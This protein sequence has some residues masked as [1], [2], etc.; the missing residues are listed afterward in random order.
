MPKSSPALELV[1]EDLSDYVA[2]DLTHEFIPDFALS[3][4]NPNPYNVRD[5]A[6]ADDELIESIREVGLVEPLVVAPAMLD[7]DGKPAPT[8]GDHDLVAGHR[9]LDGLLRIG[10]TTAPVII[11]HDL[12]TRAKQLEA[13][14][15]ENDRRQGL[16]PIEQAKGYHQ[17]TLFGVKQAEIAKKV[18][19]DRKTVAGRLKL[20][21]LNS[22]TQTKVNDGQITIDDAIAIAALP[23]AEQ[24]KLAKTAGTYSFKYDLERAQMR[25]KKTTEIDKQVADLVA[26]GVPERKYPAGKTAWN[27]TDASDGMTSLRQTFSNEPN[28]HPG[29]L[30]W[31]R[32]NAVLLEYVCTDIA[33]HD[34][35]L[36]EER[37]LAREEDER[38]AAEHAA[39]EEALAIAQR[40]RTDAI[41]ES[42]RPG[43]RLDPAVERV[44][45]LLLRGLLLE[46]GWSTREYF[47]ALDI[48][49][50][51]R[52]GEYS[53]QW[54]DVDIERFNA[55][56]DAAK[57]PADVLKLLAAYAISRA[58][59][60]WFS[61]IEPNKGPRSSHA[62]QYH[63]LARAYLNVATDAGHELTPVEQEL[64]APDA[65]EDGE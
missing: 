35:Q 45:R 38:E 40:L 16:T 15:V 26:A 44:L 17:L 50:E 65:D 24:T 4:I 46:L 39:R 48:P 10:A 55:H 23:A 1:P 19:V 54:K 7:E 63:V 8:G 12:D 27:V 58:E 56:I 30:A 29:C 31:V 62:E 28:D 41:L 60:S 32:P 42:I 59:A 52:W 61:F 6:I 57:R 47:T 37:R 53:S 5:R 2:S 3:R 18:G 64:V 33:R 11:R 9:R 51:E 20:L 43:V 22:T 21:G 49:A 34:E 13:M 36:D 14:I 25:V